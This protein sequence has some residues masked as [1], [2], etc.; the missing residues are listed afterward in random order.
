MK[1]LLFLAVFG[2]LFSGA[3]AQSPT[4]YQF[5]YSASESSATA[6]EKLRRWRVANVGVHVSPYGYNFPNMTLQGLTSLSVRPGDIGHQL[7]G[8]HQTEGYGTHVLGTYL[9][10]YVSLN[11]RSR[12]LG[13]MNTRQELRL[14][15][16]YAPNREAMI[17]YDRTL[18]DRDGYVRE[19][20]TYCL[21]ESELLVS[22]SYLF[23]TT[24]GPYERMQLFAGPGGQLSSTY[25]NL[26]FVIGGNV[27]N[28]ESGNLAAKASQYLKGY[29]H[30][31]FDYEFVRNVAFTM[32][33][34]RGM[35]VQ[36]VHGGP[37]NLIGSFWSTNVGLQYQF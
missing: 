11:P 30:A 2:C 14:G 28:L 25:D 9:G 31:G 1:K 21:I 3:Y 34:Q 23:K 15:V 17:E 4:D 29:V 5:S 26:L 10:A 16:A 19:Y 22:A 24:W 36:F 18:P 7:E 6:P 37:N 13:A 8:F 20:I 33:W 12:R 35:G 27:A 32:D